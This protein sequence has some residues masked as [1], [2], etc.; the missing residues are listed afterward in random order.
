MATDGFKNFHRA[1]A[2]ELSLEFQKLYKRAKSEFKSLQSLA[3]EKIVQADLKGD[4]DFDIGD[5]MTKEQK[6]VLYEL[7]KKKLGKVENMKEEING[8]LDEILD[9]V[10][11]SSGKNEYKYIKRRKTK[12]VYSDTTRKNEVQTRSTSARTACFCFPSPKTSNK[13]ERRQ[14]RKRKKNISLFWT[15]TRMLLIRQRRRMKKQK[16]L[17]EQLRKKEEAREM[18]K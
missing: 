14:K 11:K 7:I 16:K 2:L 1:T 17:E 4:Y 5:K 15:I 18:K 10:I 9:D 6:D 13:N 12:N 8:I 3:Q